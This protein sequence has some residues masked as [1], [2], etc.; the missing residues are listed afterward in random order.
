MYLLQKLYLI[1]V[2]VYWLVGVLFV[3]ENYQWWWLFC[4]GLFVMLAIAIVIVNKYKI[5]KNFFHFLI[6]P[7]V[8]CFTS[9]FFLTFLVNVYIYNAVSVLCAV[10]LYF[11]L[12]QYYTYFYF[13]HRYQPYSLESLSTYISMISSFFLFSGL[14]SSFILLKFGITSMVLVLVIV[15]AVLIYYYFW[16]N[17][18]DLKKSGIFI[19]VIVA[20]LAELFV[21]V[22]YLP[23]SYYVNAFILSI[24]LTLM[25]VLSRNFF[26]ASL[27]KKKII[28]HLA[29]SSI[30]LLIVLLTA[31]WS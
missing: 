10:I 3:K 20:I 27:T 29:V 24:A 7:I 14:Y 6:L 11:L 4:I 25:L 9:F 17:K 16:I 23:T 26:V 28:S 13:T 1:F 5:N 31:K 18:I 2:S 30:I 8:F 19:L 22:S 12:R 21:A 15:E